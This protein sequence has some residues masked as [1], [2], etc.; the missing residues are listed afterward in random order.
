MSYAVI[1]RED[2]QIPTVINE[3]SHEFPAYLMAG[4][5]IVSEGT[6]RECLDVEAEILS[7]YQI[8]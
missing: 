4:Y 7:Q 5:E 3:N 8:N 1:V 6:K 2:I